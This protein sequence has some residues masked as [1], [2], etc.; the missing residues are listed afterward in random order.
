MILI[1]LKIQLIFHFGQKS[2][3]EIFEKYDITHVL[4]LKSNVIAQYLKYDNNY[5]LLYEDDSFALYEKI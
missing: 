2:Y 5:N 3:I 1:Y 4:I